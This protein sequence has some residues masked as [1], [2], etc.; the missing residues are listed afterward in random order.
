MTN[1]LSMPRSGGLFSSVAIESGSFSSWSAAP[2]SYSEQVYG[3][4]LAYTGCKDAA[5]L[6]DL[7]ASKLT[8]AVNN[9]PIGHCCG[10]LAGKPFIPWS[11]TIDGVELKEH[12]WQL[13]RK[14]KLN[15]V[16]ILHGTNLD[17][18][19][20][21]EQLAPTVSSA[22]Y[23]KVF[24]SWYGPTMGNDN[25]SRVAQSY[26]DKEV[27]PSLPS[28][29]KSWWAAERSDT[30]QSFS[31]SARFASERLSALGFEVYQY[32][33]THASGGSQIVYHGSE[34]PFVFMTIG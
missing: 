14:G 2:M 22:D 12:P 18:G 24:V 15:K 9:I 27:H 23:M 7:R 30:D 5:C 6:Q 32:F 16:P 34:I 29:T 19:A 13:A 4:V 33:F 3:Q 26:L 25:A 1:H 31:C 17:E 28:V 20:G 11:P 8:E 21:F 10:D